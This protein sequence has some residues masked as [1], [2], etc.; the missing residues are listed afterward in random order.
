MSDIDILT[1]K[2]KEL[3]VIAKA[4]Q[5]SLDTLMRALWMVIGAIGFTQVLLPLLERLT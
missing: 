3:E 2:I 4:H 5:R 1:Y